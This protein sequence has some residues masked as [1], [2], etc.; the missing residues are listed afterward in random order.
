[1][2]RIDSA[3][4]WEMKIAG[5]DMIYPASVPGSVYSDLIHAGRLDDPYYRDN[6]GNR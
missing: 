2:K 1:M 3:Q 4:S 5:E 6:E